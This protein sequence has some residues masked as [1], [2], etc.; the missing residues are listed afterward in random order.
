MQRRQPSEKVERFREDRAAD[1]TELQRK[2][3]RY[4]ANNLSV[5]TISDPDI[6]EGLN[7]RAADN[8]RTML[9]IADTAGGHW[10]PRLDGLRR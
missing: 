3:I 9:A 10:P 6:P 2:A 7:D 5:L 1:L 4:V 8:W